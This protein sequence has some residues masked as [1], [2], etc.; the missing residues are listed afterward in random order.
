MKEMKIKRNSVFKIGNR[1]SIR[2]HVSRKKQHYPIYDLFLI[3]FLCIFDAKIGCKKK[4]LHKLSLAA[5][6][7]KLIGSDNYILLLRVHA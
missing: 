5:D 6:L 1:L 3:V 7:L 4:S 2:R